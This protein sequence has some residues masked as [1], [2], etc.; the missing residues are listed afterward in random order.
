[1]KLYQEKQYLEL[2]LPQYLELEGDWEKSRLILKL[3]HWKS[4]AIFV[5]LLWNFVNIIYSWDSHFDQ[6]S[7]QMNKNC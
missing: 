2:L 7:L 3:A 6:V 5:Q 4:L 1:M